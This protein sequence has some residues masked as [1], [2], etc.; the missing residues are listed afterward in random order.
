MSP[1]SGCPR[2]TPPACASTPNPTW[3]NCAA[4][5]GTRSTSPC[6][7]APRSSTSPAPALHRRAQQRIDLGLSLGSRL[8][9]YCTS[10]GK[11]LLAYLP[12][13]SC[14]SC[15]GNPPGAAHPQHDHQQAPA[16]DR[17]RSHPRGRL[18]DQR[19]RA[20]PRPALDCGA[21]PLGLARG[22]RRR[23]H[24]GAQ[25][26]D[27]PAGPHRPPRPPPDRYR[28]SH[29][30]APWISPRRRD[31]SGGGRR[32]SISLPSGP[33]RR[34]AAARRARVPAGSALRGPSGRQASGCAG[35]GVRRRGVPQEAS[36]A[37]SALRLGLA[38]RACAAVETRR[39]PSRP[40]AR[41]PRS[42]PG[43][44]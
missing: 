16:A 17:A 33:A 8:P 43:C 18:R 36:S 40:R 27:L 37:A 28:R 26:D 24:G 39:R 23:Q 6:S 32:L 19:R 11:L 31:R 9:V 5:P 25:L 20:Q 35:G 12:D 29:L 42:R 14:A 22:R 10:M 21:D 38:G 15:S 41:S 4:A 13:P 1:T 34:S 7:T 2:S 30:L 3:T 44:W